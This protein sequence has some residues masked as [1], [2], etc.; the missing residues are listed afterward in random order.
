MA[1]FIQD[2][3]YGFQRINRDVK[4]LRERSVKIGIIGGNSRYDDS[5]EAEGITVVDYAIINE[6]GTDTIPA[7]PFMATTH[8]RYNRQISKFTDFMVQRMIDGKIT[9]NT[10][11]Q[12]IGLRY[13][14]LIRKTIKEAKTWAA[15]N[16]PRTIAEK[17]SSSPLIDTGRMVQAV[18]YEV[19]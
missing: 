18:N 14:S 5:D 8:D 4:R 16:A 11:L 9:D 19:K 12:N 1:I 10:L 7:R 15:P 6:F 3:D 13:Q 17:G 2:N